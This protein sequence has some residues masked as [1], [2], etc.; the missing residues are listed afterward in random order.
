MTLRTS[1]FKGTVNE[2]EEAQRFS[3]LSPPSVAGPNDLAVSPAGTTLALSIA[4]GTCM[5]AGIHIENTSSI[6]ITIPRSGASPRWDIVGL[7]VTWNGASSSV[8]AFT[9]AGT[10]TS[11]PVM[12]NRPG[13]V[14]EYPLA[15]V[16][17]NTS[18]TSFLSGDVNDLR[19]WGGVGGPYVVSQT[20][21]TERLPLPVGS[22]FR[23]GDALYQVVG[24]NGDDLQVVLV[25]AQLRSWKAF[26]PSLYNSRGQIVGSSIFWQDGRFQIVDGACHIVVRLAIYGTVWNWTN[27][28]R[29]PYGLSLPVPVGNQMTDQWLESM[30]TYPGDPN[31]RWRGK[32]LC[33]ENA[34]RGLLYTVV[35]IN[36]GRFR[37][38]NGRPEIITIT[39]S[40]LIR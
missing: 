36:D 32:V 28:D 4:A 6:R 11:P 24:M 33:R 16:R 12:E 25:D 22:E 27:A 29:E 37:V 1:G 2:F 8:E 14:V 15:Q 18:R 9:K 35:G 21:R 23:A 38:Q 39:G 10:S 20:A 19:A 26:V 34:H 31:Q 5:V 17:V 3:I 13:E 30:T 7:R 40:Y